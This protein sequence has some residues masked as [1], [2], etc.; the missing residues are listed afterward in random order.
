MHRTGGAG[1]SNDWSWSQVSVLRDRIS[2]R[3]EDIQ[4]S[5]PGRLDPSPWGPAEQVVS[6]CAAGFFL[7][8]AAALLTEWWPHGLFALLRSRRLFRIILA[9]AWACGHV[10]LLSSDTQNFFIKTILGFTIIDKLHMQM[11]LYRLDCESPVLGDLSGY[12]SPKYPESLGRERGWDSHSNF[13]YCNRYF[14]WKLWP[15]QIFQLPWS[16][17]KQPGDLENDKNKTKQTNTKFHQEG[18]WL[19]KDWYLPA[20]AYHAI[21]NKQEVLGMLLIS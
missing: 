16:L 6:V 9:A 17:W 10:S 12:E 8:A 7:W 14:F 18:G 13:T 2:W 5:M 3:A 15:H 4:H 19:S 20:V 21:F 11:Y 1:G